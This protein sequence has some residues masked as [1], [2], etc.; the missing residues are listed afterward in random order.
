MQLGESPFCRRTAS[1]NVLCSDCVYIIAVIG[2]TLGVRFRIPAGTM[3]IPAVLAALAGI[4][5]VPATP[6]PPA[7]L[8]AANFGS[9]LADR[10][11]L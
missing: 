8:G 9:G 1:N 11:E 5:R 4:I 2:A 6:W 10:C 7:I 3:I